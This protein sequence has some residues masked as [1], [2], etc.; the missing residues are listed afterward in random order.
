MAKL[1]DITGKAIAG[2]WG[3]DDDNGTGIPVLRTTNFTNEGIVDF[4]NV[5]T[6]TITK[7]NIAE[8]YLRHG[9][10]IIEKSGGSDKQPV[11]RVIF[12]EG[13]EQKYL[14]NNFTG[15]LRVRDSSKW[16]PRYIFYTLFAR[17]RSGGT[18]AFEN[19]TTGLHNLQTDAYVNSVDV[20]DK[21]LNQQHLIC[22]VLDRI[23]QIIAERRQQ[24]SALDNLI[25][26]RFVEMFG[27]CK[28]SCPASSFMSDL[29]NGVSPSTGGKIHAKVLTLSAITQGKFDPDM[30][31][32]GLFDE[33]PPADKRITATDFYMCRGNGNKKLVGAGVC[34][35][36]DRE[37][38][39]FPDTV[40]AAHVDTSQVSLP[41]LFV[42][43]MLPEVRDQIEA[44]ARTTNGTFKIN[45]QIISRIKVPIPPIEL[46]NQFATFIAQ[47]DKSKFAIQQS[48]KETQTL[49]DS[50]MQQYFG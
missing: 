38:L 35:A 45:Q 26:A 18:R 30:W 14:F 48:L 16:L 15:L 13:P 21:A 22:D 34:S 50:L 2:E 7:R 27:E 42:A 29:R 11:G 10:I 8:K 1:I 4:S 17:Y 24:L 33:D 23:N 6:R 20:A 47:I 37:D 3:T 5:V 9:D 41:Y 31:K 43:W 39:V 49:F 36:T 46:Q 44:G 28:T 25:K 12:F 19:R 32:D 40:I